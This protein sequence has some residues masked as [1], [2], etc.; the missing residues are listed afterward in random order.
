MLDFI[1]DKEDTRRAYFVDNK[2]GKSSCCSRRRMRL[3]R[4]HDLAQI[5]EGGPVRR[6]V[7]YREEAPYKRGVYHSYNYVD[8]RVFPFFEHPHDKW[9][10]KRKG[11]YV[12]PC[13]VV[14]AVYDKR[15]G[16]QSLLHLLVEL[17]PNVYAFAETTDI[18]EVG[19]RVIFYYYKYNSKTKKIYGVV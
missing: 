17:A 16:Y 13:K 3:I 15:E 9:M 12:F 5:F 19:Q 11:E 6:Y 8:C 1:N 18:I 4:K 7:Y 2:S 10:Q 14:A